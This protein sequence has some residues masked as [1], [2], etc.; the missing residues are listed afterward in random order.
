MRDQHQNVFV[1]FEFLLEPNTGVQIQVIRRLIEQHQVRLEEERA[2]ERDAHSPTTREI[3]EL[4]LLHLR[5]EAQT[6]QDAGCFG[7]GFV[8]IEFVQTVVNLKKK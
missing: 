1:S 2:G 3:G 7:F 6:G 4:F 8:D 5:G